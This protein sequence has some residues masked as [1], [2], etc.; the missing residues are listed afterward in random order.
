MESLT[1]KMRSLAIA[2][3]KSRR[4]EIFQRTRNLIEMNETEEEQDGGSVG[5]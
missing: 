3:L 2:S 5:S 4:E 1:N